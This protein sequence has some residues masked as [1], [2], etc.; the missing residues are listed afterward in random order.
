ML[1]RAEVQFFGKVQG[2]SFREYTRRYALDEGVR[3]WVENL[4]DRTVRAVFEGD[5]ADIEQVIHRLCKEHPVAEVERFE[6]K[7]KEPTGEFAS[8]IIRK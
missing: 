6:A 2:V 4:P 8:F 1:T 7:W 5:R 3:G